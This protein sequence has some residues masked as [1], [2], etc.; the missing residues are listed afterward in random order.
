MHYEDIKILEFNQC[1][2]SDKTPFIIYPD[3]ESLIEKT[4]GCEINPEK[5]FTVKVGEH[6]SLSFSMSA[7]LYHRLKAYI[8]SMMYI[9]VKTGY[10]LQVL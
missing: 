1:Q 5:L 6:I 9:K 7:I 8:I 4:D 2:K 3:L 10:K